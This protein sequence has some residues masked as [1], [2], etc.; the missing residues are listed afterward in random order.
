MSL[1]TR[2]SG[3]TTES[4]P[5]AESDPSDIWQGARP[6]ASNGCAAGF[7]IDRDSAA[8]HCLSL[9]NLSRAVAGDL[10]T[11]ASPGVPEVED[12]PNNVLASDDFHN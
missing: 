7:R 5:S 8:P 6:Y 2:L 11:G 10:K 9:S 4:D 3:Q 1:S 12:E